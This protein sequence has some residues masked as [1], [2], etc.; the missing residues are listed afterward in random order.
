MEMVICLFPFSI[1]TVLHIQPERSGQ[2]RRSVS[3][4]QLQLSENGD[5]YV[6]RGRTAEEI[7]DGDNVKKAW[8]RCIDS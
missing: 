1:P 6:Q 7:G 5:N 2:M 8:Y 4:S 3:R